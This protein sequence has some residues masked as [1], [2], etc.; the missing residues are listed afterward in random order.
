MALFC[1]HCLD[2]ETEG[3]ARRAETRSAHL[4]WV[5]SLGGTCRM[6]GPLL[7]EDGRMIGS[8]FL[9]ETANLAAAQAIHAEDPYV[10]AG[11]FDAV[12]INETR[13]AIGDGKPQ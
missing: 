3:S 7:S 10:K 9:F 13:W 5:A 6:A 2:D 11:V 1:L 8:I 12:T 4:A